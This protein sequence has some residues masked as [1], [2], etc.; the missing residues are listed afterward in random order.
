MGAKHRQSEVE[1]LTRDVEALRARVV[2]VPDVRDSPYVASDRA[3]NTWAEMADDENGEW[4]NIERLARLNGKTVSEGLLRCC[5]QRLQFYFEH[6]CDESAKEGDIAMAAEARDE[7]REL[8]DNWK[9]NG[10]LGD[11][12]KAGAGPYS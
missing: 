11:K 10:Q 4:V 8:L 3:G 2:V 5:E 9:G 7:L 1:Q 6:L 12:Q